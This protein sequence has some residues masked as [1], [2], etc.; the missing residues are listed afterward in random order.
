[1]R[2]FRNLIA[3]AGLA[4]T[5][6]LSIAAPSAPAYAADL[7]VTA[8]NV[9]QGSDASVRQGVAGEALTQ[10]QYVYQDATTRK[11]LKADAD[12]VSAA[13][14]GANG[15]AVT[16]NA[17]STDQPITVQVGGLLTPGATLTAG[18]A[19]YLSGTAGGICPLADVG[20]G[21]YVVLLGLARSTSVLDFAPR[22]TG[23]AN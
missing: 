10:G 23:V 18:V 20:T 12:A 15:L 8:A 7:S 13:A 22:Y 4:A 21:E 9:K 1:M 6:A 14:R 16:L 3:C 17:A 19:Y 5:L 11:W 2:S